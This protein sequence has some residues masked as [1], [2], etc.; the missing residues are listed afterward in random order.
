MIAFADP[1]PSILEL[2]PRIRAFL[3]RRVPQAD[4]DDCCQVVLLKAW[5]GGFDPSKASLST[6]LFTIA[7][8]VVIDAARS[9]NG[10]RKDAR[11]RACGGTEWAA[12]HREPSPNANLMAEATSQD[13]ANLLAS[14]RPR[15]A[16]LLR[17]HYLDG[18]QHDRL[19]GHFGIPIGTVKSR[20]NTLFN[21]IRRGQ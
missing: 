20:L 2:E 21:H 14:L 18:W 11:A 4:L 19:A 7:R 10:R 13:V 9:R 1:L 16:E 6:W 5:R 8:R 12:D 3:A 17:L 15:D